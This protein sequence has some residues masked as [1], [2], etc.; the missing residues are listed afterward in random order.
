LS[1]IGWRTGFCK[2]CFTS[3]IE[4]RAHGG[5]A[6]SSNSVKSNNNLSQWYV[7]NVTIRVVICR[8]DASNPAARVTACLCDDCAH[9]SRTKDYWGLFFIIHI[10]KSSVISSLKNR[11]ESYIYT[12]C[13]YLIMSINFISIYI[14]LFVHVCHIL[15]VKLH[16]FLWILYV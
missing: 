7:K 4:L 13:T 1:V 2:R 12:S 5:V 3:A 15:I 14:L 16:W 8:L 11:S 10:R 6:S 9:S